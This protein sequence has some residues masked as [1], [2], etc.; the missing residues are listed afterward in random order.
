[1]FAK[2]KKISLAV[3][4]VFMAV[5]FTG[6]VNLTRR[7][8]ATQRV[9]NVDQGVFKSVDGGKTWEHKVNIEGGD[10]LD[11]IAI[12]ALKIDPKENNI[13]YLGTR[14]NG[15][16]KTENGADTWFK[17]SDES[18][19][20]SDTATINDI[21]IEKNNN[22]IIYVA[23]LNNAIGVLLKSEDGG[24][25]WSEAYISSESNKTVNAV[26]IDPISPNVVYIGTAQGGLLRSDNRGRSWESIA[27]FG[28]TS[29]V[30]EIIIDKNNNNGI[31]LRTSDDVKK[32]T[33]KGVTWETLA[34]KIRE[35]I[36]KANMS[37]INSITPNLSN[38]L[39]LY[40]TYKNLVITT[41]DGGT[42]WEILE[43]ITPAKTALG[44]IPQ[45]KQIGL[46][47]S[48]MYYGA[49][50]ALY[51]SSDSGKTWSSYAISIKGDVRYTESDHV[52]PDVI[53][54]GSFYTPPP[55]KKGSFF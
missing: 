51:K 4:L 19:I 24:K 6:C 12:T 22:K 47:D 28:A 39:T 36:P 29:E 14:T 27:W 3:L 17:V 35:A 44:T 42:T 33:D 43:T 26:E 13:L 23:A 45:I 10:F 21:A 54:V 18:K 50:N 52:N 48:I 34:K 46:I 16:Y 30:K 1:M 38:P 40:L 7:D 15:I 37:M 2:I 41:N 9:V 11:S 32:T 49:G 25:N 20:L 5:Y 55:K 8:S 31:I 53:Y